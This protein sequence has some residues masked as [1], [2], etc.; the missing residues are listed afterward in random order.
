L[1]QFVGI[2]KNVAKFIAACSQRLGRQLRGHLDSRHG[3]VFR[4][5][6][7]LVDLNARVSRHRGL[8]LLRQL[9][10]FCVAA[11]KRANKAREL[12]L[13]QVFRE[14]NTGDSRRCQK[15]RETPLASGRSQRHAVQQDLRP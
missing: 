5:K 15:L 12:G 13:R 2:F 7:N 8:Q 10:G 3:A 14:V 11:G 1:Q 9:A 6:P 4:N